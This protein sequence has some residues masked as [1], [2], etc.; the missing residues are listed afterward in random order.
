MEQ[1]TDEE[2][3]QIV[4][5]VAEGAPFWKIND[6]INRSR[7]AV[8]RAIRRTKRPAPP[9]RRRSPLRLSLEER[10]EISRGLA[11]GDSFRAMKD[12]SRLGRP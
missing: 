4:A 12:V 9:E 11:A 8:A 5:L 1:I 3:A 10:E 7:W 6:E 2:R